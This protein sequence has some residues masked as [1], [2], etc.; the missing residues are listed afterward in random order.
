M[1]TKSRKAMIRAYNNG[2]R[3]CYCGVQLNWTGR[4]PNSATFEHLVPRSQGGTWAPENG[5]IV[6]NSCNNKREN[7]CWI[8]Y[9]N[10][11]NPPKKEWLIQKYLEAVLYHH[12]RG[13]NI[14]IRKKVISRAQREC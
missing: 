1:P 9:L 3:R 11:V 8:R 7:K 12:S 14:N 4:F 13:I 10:E 5:M 6:C 2:Q